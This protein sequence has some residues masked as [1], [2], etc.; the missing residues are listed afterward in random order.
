MYL[1]SSNTRAVLLLNLVLHALLTS[2]EEG[3]RAFV[4]VPALLLVIAVAPSLNQVMLLK[5]TASGVR[6]GHTRLVS[7]RVIL[8]ACHRSPVLVQ[9]PVSQK[10]L[11]PKLP[12]RATRTM[13]DA[14]K[15]TSAPA[16]VETEAEASQSPNPLLA[17]RC[18]RNSNEHRSFLYAALHSQSNWF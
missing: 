10:W 6:L 12:F 1:P 2:V 9:N 3:P 5:A 7:A 16:V 17:V 4:Q 13:S 18:Q 14:P 11:Q 8:G 15:A